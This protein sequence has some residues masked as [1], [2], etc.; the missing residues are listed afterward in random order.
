MKTLTKRDIIAWMIIVIT[1]ILFL[2]IYLYDRQRTE[3]IRIALGATLEGK[4]PTLQLDIDDR[5]GF[6]AKCKIEP[7]GVRTEGDF[8]NRLWYL[9]TCGSEIAVDIGCHLRPSYSCSLSDTP[10]VH[11]QK[12]NEKIAQ[13]KAALKESNSAERLSK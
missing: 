6:I 4:T 7:V 12:L 5:L 10:E 13:E 3:N 8:V 9:G 11:M 1:L 2:G